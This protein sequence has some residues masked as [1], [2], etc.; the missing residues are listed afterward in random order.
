[1]LVTA[2]L[3]VVFNYPF[4]FATVLAGNIG[5]NWFRIMPE[6]VSKLLHAAIWSCGAVWLE[7][8]QMPVLRQVLDL[9]LQLLQDAICNRLLCSYALFLVRD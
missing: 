7:S 9:D 6:I 2:G 8:E 3:Y 5:C 1:M 4:S